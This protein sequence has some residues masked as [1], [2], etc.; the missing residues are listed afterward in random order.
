LMIGSNSA[1]GLS[2]GFFAVVVWGWLW[3]YTNQEDSRNSTLLASISV[4]GSLA[5]IGGM[6][7]SFA[8]ITSAYG[9][10]TSLSGRTDIWEASLAALSERPLFGYG[11]GA[12]FWRSDVSPETEA[13]WRHVGFESSH[14]HNGALDLAI[15]IG[16]I[17]LLIFTVLWVSVAISAWRVL[18]TNPELGIWI[19]SVVASNFVI[20]LT[21]DVFY[22]GWIG[23]FIMMRV[24]LMRR[25]SSLTMP[26]WTKGLSRWS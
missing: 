4:L 2:G 21:E 1:T 14:A 8:T 7:A 12:L 9:K 18:P 3:V 20:G 6:I 5:V 25:E 16:L 15:Q 13:I 22:G 10:D 24:L 17:G 26:S 23:V 19:L 11:F